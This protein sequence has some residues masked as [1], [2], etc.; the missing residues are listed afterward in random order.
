MLK[1]RLRLS[2]FLL[3]TSLISLK[4][5]FSATN[6]LTHSNSLPI[7]EDP[8]Y[9]IFLQDLHS[10]IED[11]L[12]ISSTPPT[13]AVPVFPYDPILYSIIRF[14]SNLQS[15]VSLKITETLLEDY[16]RRVSQIRNENIRNSILTYELI[17]WSAEIQRAR[18]RE[19]VL[20]EYF[21]DWVLKERAYR[22]IIN[23]PKKYPQ[24]L[25]PDF[26][27]R[28][29][30]FLSSLGS[31]FNLEGFAT[32][33]INNTLI[34]SPQENYLSLNSRPR[35]GLLGRVISAFSGRLILSQVRQNENNPTEFNSINLFDGLSYTLRDLN[36]YKILSDYYRNILSSLKSPFRS[37]YDLSASYIS[38]ITKFIKTDSG[39]LVPIEFN[40]SKIVG[41][42]TSEIFQDNKVPIYLRTIIG[43]AN[44]LKLYEDVDPAA[45]EILL[46]IFTQNEALKSILLE[47][48]RSSNV[49][50]TTLNTIHNF[51]V[52]KKVLA[53]D[54]INIRRSSAYSSCVHQSVKSFVDSVNDLIST[55]LIMNEG[56]SFYNELLNKIID[57][58]SSSIPLTDWVSRRLVDELITV[59]IRVERLIDKIGELEEAKINYN[60]V[61]ASRCLPRPSPCDINAYYGENFRNYV[62]PSIDRLKSV[63]RDLL[64]EK[65]SVSGLSI[66]YNTIG[67]LVNDI[68]DGYR[69]GD[70]SSRIITPDNL[71]AENTK[72][73]FVRREKILVKKTPEIKFNIFLLFASIF[74][75]KEVNIIKK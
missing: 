12:N 42:Y 23:F 66:V 50:T 6:H 75:P 57:K 36:N 73:I 29:F 65:T 26:A 56:Y 48:E 47:D 67:K 3:I 58:A 68:S 40:Y 70:S 24:C 30:E 19:K 74:E 25:D 38:E 27:P 59:Q 41:N 21:R 9:S 32:K 18:E 46:H 31:I 22:A 51:C 61:K 39:I 71:I 62:L 52:N 54:V 5:T 8:N 49:L 72:N 69:E 11:L 53:S 20:G 13:E 44:S 33:I 34:C 16:L 45:S 43:N 63:L 35:L 15:A 10:W 37:P 28:H 17:G 55:L 60:L 4:F 1:S 7:Y 2:I 14:S 64:Q